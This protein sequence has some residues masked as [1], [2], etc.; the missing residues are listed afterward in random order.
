MHSDSGPPSERGGDRAPSDPPVREGAEETGERLAFLTYDELIRIFS[1]VADT[2]Y[3]RAGN[4]TNLF[5]VKGQEG[6]DLLE[7]A[8]ANP[9][10]PW[11]PDMAA[12]A[13]GLFCSLIQNH[14]LNDGNK[15]LAVVVTQTFILRN[16]YLLPLSNATIYGV[17]IAVAGHIL[18]REQVADL[19]RKYIIYPDREDPAWVDAVMIRWLED[20]GP[21]EVGAYLGDSATMLQELLRVIGLIVNPPTP[22]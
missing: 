13:A 11:H 3:R 22:N 8:L 7:A 2:L 20:L 14:G 1:V 21:D 18:S 5:T 10:W 15:R 4:G 16:G 6:R 9:Q 12:R 19:F 17:S